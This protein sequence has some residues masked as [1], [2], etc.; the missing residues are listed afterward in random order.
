L[1]KTRIRI[2]PQQEAEDRARAD[3]DLREALRSFQWSMLSDVEE[4]ADYPDHRRASRPPSV[5]RSEGVGE[6]PPKVAS[7][8][9]QSDEA[10]A[11]SYRKTLWRPITQRRGID[12]ELVR[13]EEAE[14]LEYVLR[15]FFAF[16][17]AN[18]QWDAVA[19][20]VLGDMTQTQAAEFL[21]CSQQAVDHR[22]R[23]AAAAVLRVIDSSRWGRSV[24]MRVAPSI[25]EAWA[26]R[27]IIQ[28][29][30]P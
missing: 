24:F 18:A 16:A 1:A 21:G 14:H 10:T 22:L 27:K 6:S 28:E 8:V 19:M 12:D 30:K 26:V 29:N 5:A 23:Y 13:R 15:A 4:R 11:K 20:C 2:D 7:P 3:A 9:A 17:G 25:V